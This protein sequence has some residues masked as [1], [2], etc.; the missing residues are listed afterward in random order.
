MVDGWK[1][2]AEVG[3]LKASCET[4]EAFEARANAF[5]KD[6]AEVYR[7]GDARNLH[8]ARLMAYA[9]AYK[10]VLYFEAEF[11]RA[12]RR[13]GSDNRDVPD[14]AALNSRIRILVKQLFGLLPKAPS[15][16]P[17]KKET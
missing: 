8:W 15:L 1:N 13:P 17:A 5:A 16:G 6:L 9:G 14:E 7:L 11:L 4:L 2:L 10:T 12:R 3:H